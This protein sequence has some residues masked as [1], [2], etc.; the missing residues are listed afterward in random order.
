MPFYAIKNIATNE[1]WTGAV[2]DTPGG[3]VD[4]FGGLMGRS[5]T[6]DPVD[7]PASFLLAEHTDPGPHWLDF[8]IPVYRAVRARPIA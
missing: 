2:S 3:A 6:L 8:R 4:I 7:R 5:L 1:V